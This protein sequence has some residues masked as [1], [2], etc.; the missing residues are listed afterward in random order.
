MT[1]FDDSNDPID[2][3]LGSSEDPDSAPSIETPDY[4]ATRLL[5][6]RRRVR[7]SS[8][9]IG[10]TRESAGLPRDTA[11]NQKIKATLEDG[12]R[13][14]NWVDPPIPSKCRWRIADEVTI[15]HDGDTEKPAHFS[16]LQRCGSISACPVCS[17]VIRAGR[18]EEIEIMAKSHMAQG[19]HLALLTLTLRHSK[20][21][22]YELTLGTVNKAWGRVSSG[23]S[24]ND[25]TA[26]WGIEHWV[27]ATETT[28]GVVNGWHPHIHVLLFLKS[29]LKKNE[30]SA[31][32]T[33]LY[34][35]WSKFVVKLGCQ[36]P[37][38]LR[39]VDIRPV[40]KD[41]KLLAQYLAK[42]QDMGSDSP[43][44][45][46]QK[47]SPNKVKIGN[48][49]ARADFK[50][51]RAGNITPFQLL[52][53]NG[54]RSRELFL[55]Y[56]F[57][58]KGKRLFGWSKDVRKTYL[59]EPEK[60]DKQLLD[61]AEKSE[62]FASIPGDVYDREYRDDPDKATS[63]LE[64]VEQR[65]EDFVPGVEYGVKIQPARDP[66]DVAKRNKLAFS[67]RSR[68]DQIAEFMLTGQVTD[69]N[70]ILQPSRAQEYFWLA[71]NS[72]WLSVRKQIHGYVVRLRGLGVEIPKK[73]DVDTW[74]SFS[75]D[76]SGGSALP[77][78]FRPSMKPLD[79]KIRDHKA[80][81]KTNPEFGQSVELV[82]PE[83]DLPEDFAK[84]IRASLS[85][86]YGVPREALKI[87]LS[88]KSDPF[89]EVVMAEKERNEK[90]RQRIAEYLRT[91]QI[92]DAPADWMKKFNANIDALSKT[93]LW[94]EVQS[95]YRQE[96]IPDQVFDDLERQLSSSDLRN[97]DPSVH[98]LIFETREF[99][100][101][102]LKPKR[103]A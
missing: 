51:G 7:M 32:K 26:K 8:W 69:S 2:D 3:F 94:Q 54:E 9:L 46:E 78:T 92:K 6:Y 82:D 60:T 22:P 56:Y 24:W 18:A 23:K 20:D 99:L 53:S 35:R 96:R 27:R 80:R 47:E 39:G 87:D 4:N 17:S 77:K 42:A 11:R 72:E 70:G 28:Y 30:I 50:D 14:P 52:D 38:K 75:P 34:D 63:A 19:G 13:N 95:E 103:K 100:E 5:R 29:P 15:H 85:Q 37:T 89:P 68:R 76:L 48:E 102:Q 74:K 90:A 44:K 64:A 21:N 58:S 98:D 84:S 65:R 79:E 91:G 33:Y 59:A 61:D 16:G 40:E 31:W 45:R 10:Y 55:E 81:V 57:A 1:K 73:Y 36:L 25:F 101:D 71:N 97:E 93:D 86:K 88:I 66:E 83:L 49:M 41:G 12:S 62:Y 43:L 67:R